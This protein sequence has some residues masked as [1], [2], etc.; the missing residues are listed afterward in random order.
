MIKIIKANKTC[1]K[2]EVSK[3]NKKFREFLAPY[4]V[5][6]PYNRFKGHYPQYLIQYNG[7][8]VGSFL[9]GNMP[10]H[11]YICRFFIEEEYRGKGIG[12]KVLD[13]ILNTMCSNKEGLC[14]AAE[15]NNTVAFNLYIRL[16]YKIYYED[17]GT[18]CMMKPKLKR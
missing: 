16:G 15:K 1:H 11:R 7:K 9:L 12:T 17:E 8:L 5:G 14:L 3:F 2:K 13:E 4:C 18:C 10:E 6:K